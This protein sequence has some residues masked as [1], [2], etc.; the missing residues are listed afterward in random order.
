MVS[1]SKVIQIKSNNVKRFDLSEND[2]ILIKKVNFNNIE[3]ARW[4]NSEA[5]M[6][7]FYDFIDKGYRG[8]YAYID[9]VCVSRLWVFSNSDST[10]LNDYFLYKLKS[11][12]VYVSW[13]LTDSQYRNM[14]VFQKISAYI[15]EDN[16][17]KKVLGSVNPLN[18]VSLKLHENL[19]YYI[20]GKYFLIKFLRLRLSIRYGGT[21]S[22]RINI[23]YYV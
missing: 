21:S 10:F 13:G 1:I 23:G 11:D 6:K 12:E 8:Y 7:S 3:D 16:V 4:F 15:L 22:F 2:K 9:G 18:S 5:Q 17:G 20:F 14:G 19:G